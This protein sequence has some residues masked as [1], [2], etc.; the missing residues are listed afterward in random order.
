MWTLSLMVAAVPDARPADAPDAPVVVLANP[1][2]VP[3]PRPTLTGIVALTATATPTAGRTIQSVRFETSPAAADTWTEIVVDTTPP[4]T[5]AWNADLDGPNDLRAVA[6]DSAG[7]TGTSTLLD[8]IVQSDP[9]KRATLRDPGPNLRGVVTLTSAVTPTAG[10]TIVEARYDRHLS[11]GPRA[12]D[13]IGT[14][15]AAAGAAF[16][17]SFDTRAVPDGVYDFRVVAQDEIPSE[18]YSPTVL[19]RRIDNTPPSATLVPP[20]ATLTGRVTLRGDAADGDGSGVVRLRYERAV[21][22]TDGWTLVAADGTAPYAVTVETAGIPNGRYDLRVVAI[23][24]AGNTSSSA[25]IPGVQI[26]NPEQPPIAVPSI[27]SMAVPVRNPTIL[28]SIAGS[29]QD[30]AWAYGF[31]S[32]APAQV[33]GRRLP[34][35][36]PGAQLVL[37]RYT[38]DT[39]WQIRDVLRTP[40]GDA[41][42]LP[43]SGADGRTVVGA[44][45]PSGEA[46][47]AIDIGAAEGIFH[48]LPGGGFVLDAPATAAVGDL[49]GAG[50]TLRLRWRGAELY[51]ALSRPGQSDGQAI[52]LEVPGSTPVAVTPKLGVGLLEGGVWTRV[53][54]DVPTA[55]RPRAGDTLTLQSAD[56]DAP[57][58]VWAAVSVQSRTNAGR[59]PA[60]LVRR[61]AGQWTAT[62]TAIDALDLPDGYGSDNANV[63]AIRVIAHSSGPWL[64]A[65][66]NSATLSG[67]IVARFD[68]TG[69]ALQAWCDPSLESGGC[70][71]VL[72]AQNPAVLPEAIFAGSGGPIALAPGVARFEGGAWTR[73]PAF[74][75][76]ASFSG[77]DEGW[78]AGE[79]GVGRWT[80]NP[81]PGPLVE[82]PHA[83]RNPLLAAALPP[84]SD[85]ALASSGAVAVGI[86]GTALHYESGVGWLV[87]PLPNRAARVNLFGVAFDGPGSAVAVGQGGTIL[88]WNGSEWRLDPQSSTLTEN[89]LTAVAFS[90]SGRGWAVGRFG[91]ILHFDGNAWRA[92]QP[93]PD[94]EGVNLTSVTVAG[95]QAYAVIGGVLIVRGESG[96]WQ[97]V[98]QE[99]LPTPPPRAGELRLV[100]GLPDGGLVVAGRYVVLVRDGA[101]GR[102]EPTPQ[103]IENI[104]VAV[105]ATRAASGELRPMISVA[106]P[107]QLVNESTG[108]VQRVDVAGVPAGNGELLRQLADGTWQ[109]LSL[110][111]DPGEVIGALA[112]PVLAI[113]ASPDGSR[114][115]AVGGYAGTV[116]ASGLGTTAVLAARPVGW[117]TSSIWRFDAD[118]RRPAPGLQ[119][120][121]VEIP[122]QPSSVSFAF[123]S[124]SMCN[125]SCAL[126]QLKAQPDVN[127]RAATAQIAAFAKQPGGPSFAI[128]G[129][130]M[131]GP[132]SG[133]LWN[134]GAGSGHFAQLPALLEPLGQ[135]PLFGVFGPRD[136]VRRQDQPS[137]QWADAFAPAPAPFGS[138]GPVSNIVP[139]GSGFRDGAVN[140]YYAF[141]AN[142]NGATIRIIAID[143]SAGSLE[144]TAAGQ[145]DWLRERLAEARARSL[146]VIVTAGQ[147]LS[148]T[149]DGAELTQ[150]LVDSGVAAV[151]T[152]SLPEANVNERR[153][154]PENVPEGTPQIPAYEGGALGYQQ[155]ANNGVVW[156]HVTV[157]TAAVPAQV[158]VDAIPV[159]DSLALKPLRGLAVAR[160][161]TLQFEAIARR[162][163]SSL[164]TTPANPTIPG[165][166]NY[167]AIPTPSC[168]TR[169]CVPPSYRFTSADPTIG[170]FVTATGT[171]SPF[172]QLSGSGRTTS[173]PASGLFC[174]F[175][176]GTTTVTVKV[177]LLSYSLPVT[178]QP[179]LIGQPCGTVAR[180][181]AAPVITRRPVQG[182]AQL[183]VAPAAAPPVAS[184]TPVI[185][186]I[187]P[188]AP[189]V[190]PS[191]PVPPPLVV[192]PVLAPTLP[193]I[194][195][196][197]PRPL[198]PVP[199]PPPIIQPIPPG[200]ATAPSAS[201]APRREK[202]HKHASQSAFVIRP[203]GA[204]AFTWF[205]PATAGSGILALLL[206]A[207]AVGTRGAPRSRRRIEAAP[208]TLRRPIHVP[209]S[210]RRY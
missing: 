175:N 92:E 168:G 93:P 53:T 25:V 66:S 22:G 95:D 73:L 15:T 27:Q 2:L 129:G 55:Y 117:R 136:A 70:T 184:T 187:I 209:R 186:S 82:W 9:A 4:Y 64:Q 191:V 1:T 138:G 104:V 65:V 146:P 143:N 80:L 204:D 26:D 200:G 165:F 88:R 206:C 197:V 87:D 201:T 78:L 63:S 126:R 164:E 115:W 103:P 23:D 122:A 76:S 18:I 127:L 202:A 195:G 83:N 163:K 190:A 90:P 97:R 111:Q 169:P 34:Y 100:S 50:M 86:G 180:P 125:G 114:A 144:Q 137:E 133:E 105:A 40:S 59:R 124:G 85:G 157:D 173:N 19:S 17:L 141:D 177:G 128:A 69:R 6:T 47:M 29:P 11:A 41:F 130:N 109:D 8:L 198:I 94:F 79:F 98:A 72:D 112:D 207:G 192:P 56:M 199:P 183:N 161:A 49:I 13:A 149:R 75:T 107:A 167:V 210:P 176:A 32:A 151:F 170:D 99:L 156:Y 28:G 150:L 162:P 101:S 172:P 155:T 185:P 153:L 54:A 194:V 208:A 7:V 166:D 68:P 30:E 140:R 71:D 58:A 31:T 110:S 171:G 57:G 74:G 24:R 160:S 96:S 20:A 196:L 118:G 188:P 120:V 142:Q 193:P 42:A 60:F 147:P 48:R 205:F 135:L 33:G 178:V 37:L 91:T 61:A 38:R 45:A 181:G 123:F 139:A 108:E 5:A 113:A 132:F 159:I 121:P 39:G 134:Q 106:P 44:M 154:I 89:Q 46:W 119:T 62:E 131:R 14:A 16:P 77:P 43:Q 179:G 116:T 51:G 35:T 52:Q 84:G 182:N 152:A 158:R 174:A 36:A 67:R 203:A 102:L 21:A 189:V 145:T 81:Q 12:W 148:A 10:T 3:T